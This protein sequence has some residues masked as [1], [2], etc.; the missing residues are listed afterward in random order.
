M[1]QPVH[2]GIALLSLTVAFAAADIASWYWILFV[3]IAEN[4]TTY[5]VIHFLDV[6]QGDAELV[7]FAD[8]T[9]ILTDTGPSGPA[10]LGALDSILASRDR[11]IDIIIISQPSASHFGGLRDIVDHYRVGAI[12]YSGRDAPPGVSA[13]PT[14]LEKI[15]AKMIPLIT[16]GE[17]DCL[18]IGT[19]G[20]VDILSPGRELAESQELGD[21]GIVQ[22]VTTGKFRALLTADIGFGV[23]NALVAR[24][25][26]LLRA[27]ILKIPHGGSKNSSGA[28]FLSAVS[29]RTAIIEVGAK[30]SYHQPAAETLIRIVSSTSAKVFRTDED[31]TVAVFRASDGA[32]AAVAAR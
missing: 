29:P 2:Q 11:S 13:W 27:D 30:N 28:A 12:I 7:S 20:K 4:A 5:P 17:G 18:H 16:L 6:G 26:M 14:L 21:T 22:L 3:P 24:Y 8:G 31:G 19:L 23:E 10:I 15:S 9:N 25:G 32:L 1:K